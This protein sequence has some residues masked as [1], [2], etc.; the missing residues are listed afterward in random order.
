VQVI[1]EALQHLQP[2][3]IAL[4]ADNLFLCGTC[5]NSFKRNDFPAIS[6]A[7]EMGL[8]P[9]PSVIS[10]LNVMEVR[11]AYSLCHSVEF[12]VA[13]RDVVP[14]VVMCVAHHGQVMAVCSCGL[15]A[16]RTSS[17]QW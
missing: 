3:N 8:A 9:I 15:L 12:G 5:R 13:N 7:N 11:A 10:D 6:I 4:T 1:D 14:Y 16:E 2:H 17:K